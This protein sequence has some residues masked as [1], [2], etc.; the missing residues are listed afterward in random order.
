MAAA[1]VERVH[2]TAIAAGGRAALILGPSGAGKSD[3]ALRCLTLAPSSVIPQIALLLADDQV[4]LERQHDRL[5]ASAPAE[6]LNLIEVRGVGIMTVP[7]VSIA[8]PTPV[9]LAVEL[10]APGATERYPDPWPTLSFLGLKVPVLRLW[11]FESAAAQKVLAALSGA[12]L[13]PVVP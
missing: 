11:A 4:V 8:G 5:M 1:R 2:A 7:K 10:T 3:L 13:P 12:A 6:L 9:A